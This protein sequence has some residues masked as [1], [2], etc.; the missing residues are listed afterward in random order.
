[1]ADLLEQQHIDAGLALLRADAGLTVY[2]NAEGF[3]PASP[4]PPYVRVYTHIERPVDATGN[5]LTGLS[6]TWR[7]RW[8]LHCV[9][10]TEYAA[11]AVQMRVRTQLLDVRPAIPARN[12]GL[13]RE[14]SSSPPVRDTSTGVDVMDALAVYGL[15]TTG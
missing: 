11:A 14:E 7:V 9:G 8:Y 10:A 2:P 6:A 1:M 3:V 5:A 13:I 12:C 4:A 15:T